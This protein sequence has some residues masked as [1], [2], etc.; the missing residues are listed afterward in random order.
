MVSA[1]VGFVIYQQGESKLLYQLQPSMQISR[2]RE[3]NVA[4]IVNFAFFQ[5]SYGGFLDLVTKEKNE[6]MVFMRNISITQKKKPCSATKCSKRVCVFPQLFLPW[7]ETAS[8]GNMRS[9]R[10]RSPHITFTH[11]HTPAHPSIS[12]LQLHLE[13][14]VYRQLKFHTLCLLFIATL[15]IFQCQKVSCI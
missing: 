7:A 5:L 10:Q 4:I 8:S 1:V 14:C 15:Q 6:K 3:K 13:D 12:S 11:T 2:T 9:I